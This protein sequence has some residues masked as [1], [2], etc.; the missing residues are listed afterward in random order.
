MGWFPEGELFTTPFVACTRVFVAGFSP[1][2]YTC[3]WSRK[4]PV[5]STF[6]QQIH[7]WL[8]YGKNPRP[9]WENTRHIGGA[10]IICSF[11]VIIDQMSKTWSVMQT[12]NWIGCSAVGNV[13]RREASDKSQ[14]LRALFFPWLLLAVCCT[15]TE[16]DKSQAA[17]TVALFMAAIFLSFTVGKQNASEYGQHFGDMMSNREIEIILPRRLCMTLR[18]SCVDLMYD[19][20]NTQFYSSTPWTQLKYQ[21][22]KPEWRH[23]SCGLFLWLRPKRKQRTYMCTHTHVYSHIYIYYPGV[24]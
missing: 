18:V 2:A 19:D 9:L 21:F 4:M 3:A 8:L 12:H 22:K 11:N 1:E 20:A 10:V 23:E 7:E 5:A 14:T 15:R 24:R 17:G 16:W 6:W 13:L